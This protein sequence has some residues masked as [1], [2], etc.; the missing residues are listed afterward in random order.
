MLGKSAKLPFHSRQSYS[1]SFLHTLH[2]DVWG[3]MSIPFFDGFRFY[4]II[5]NEYSRYIWLFSMAH[6][7]DVATIFPAF[8]TQMANQLSTSVKIVQS[9]GGGEFISI[10][11]QNYFAAHGII[12]R[13]SCP[14]TPEQNGLAEWQHRHVVNTGRTLMAHASAPIKYWSAAFRTAVFLINRL[15]SSAPKHKSPHEL[16]FGSSLSFDLLWVFGCS[17]YPLLS[18]F[19]RSKLDYKSICCVFIGYSANHKGYC[20]LE[21]HSGHLY[22]SRHAK[23][24]ELHFSF[25][26]AA[27][28]KSSNPRLFQ[29]QTLPKSLKNHALPRPSPTLPTN[30]VSAIE[31]A[32]YQSSEFQPEVVSLSPTE[33]TNTLPSRIHSMVTRA[34]TSNL[35]PKLFFITRHPIPVYYLADLTAQPSQP[36][37]YHQALRLTHWK[38]AMQD[39]MD[40][41]HTNHTWAL[42]P[43]TSDMNL[44]NSKWIFKV[45]TQFDGTIDRYK[46][47]LVA[48]GF[49][50][51]PGLDYDET[52]S[53]VVKPG[54]IRL[55]LNIGLYFG[56]LIQQLDV[57][58][59]IL[60]G[61]LH[62]R[63]YLA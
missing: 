37:S 4:L 60:H 54:T 22:I 34:Q 14:G 36:S 28:S 51:L 12:H 6:K 47:K 42:V 27:I 38:K 19:G 39:E 49:T 57:S 53:P 17:W 50:Q 16:I 58:N 41:L 9:D 59:A 25:K 63:V 18:H 10:V 7:S 40:A 46:A 52:F 2:T 44:V 30:E 26:T 45:Q 1:T 56:C 62:E 55:I 13:I 32:T 31:P 11:L 33:S 8:I 35:K 29:L 61:D 5:I 23:F 24:N 15:P 48:R 21:P 43:K 3:P 20:C